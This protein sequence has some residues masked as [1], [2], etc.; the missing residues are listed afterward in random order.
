M[1]LRTFAPPYIAS[2]NLMVKNTPIIAI[3]AR[4]KLH[5][6]GDI[7]KQATELQ[8]GA[9]SNVFNIKRLLPIKVL[10]GSKTIPIGTKF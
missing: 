3:A 6:S 7:E 10:A 4:S 9:V 1:S 8:E 5:V 2:Q